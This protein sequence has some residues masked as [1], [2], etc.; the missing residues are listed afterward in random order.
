V[1]YHAHTEYYISS[2]DTAQHR[3]C[4]YLI[5]YADISLIL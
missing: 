4:T 1:E 3:T 5:M 2:Q